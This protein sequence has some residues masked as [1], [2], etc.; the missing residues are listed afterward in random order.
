M[1][2]IIIIFVRVLLEHVDTLEV[3]R[4]VP[5]TCLLTYLLTHYG[6]ART[7]R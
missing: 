6:Y 3:L 1:G 7:G 4:N 5:S 2:P